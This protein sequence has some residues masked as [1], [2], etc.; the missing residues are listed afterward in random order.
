M[1]LVLLKYCTNEVYNITVCVLF[2]V[3]LGSNKIVFKL[4]TVFSILRPRW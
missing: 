2:K 3:Y 1:T 4:Y